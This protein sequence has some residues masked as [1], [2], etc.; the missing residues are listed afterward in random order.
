[1]TNLYFGTLREGV[2]ADEKVVRQTATPYDRDAPAAMQDSMPDRGEVE[3]DPNPTLGMV[4]RQKSSLWVQGK[5]FFPWW[6]GSV[7]E[8]YEHNA[9]IDR[10][11]ST[12]GTAA[13]REAAGEWG[14][15]TAS[16]AVGIEPVGDLTD[17]GA[18]SNEYFKRNDRDIQETADPTMM[19]VPPGYDQSVNGRVSAEGK[20]ASRAAAMAGMYNT[21]WNSGN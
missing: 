12:S 2:P 20:V 8:S 10:Q 6:K 16:F 15:G 19:S 7:D 5:K 14:H 13:A 21:F 17:G 9:I 18:F 11:V 3:T 1:M 4:N